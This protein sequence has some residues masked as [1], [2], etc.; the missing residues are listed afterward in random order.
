MRNFLKI[1]RGA[2]ISG[3]DLIKKSD[4]FTDLLEAI[5]YLNPTA[6]DEQVIFMGTTTLLAITDTTALSKAVK[7]ATDEANKKAKE[8][9]VLAD[10]FN[11]PTTTENNN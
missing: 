5:H 11:S 1:N 6:S 3:V 7:V 2:K 9:S 8:V 4:L 10:M